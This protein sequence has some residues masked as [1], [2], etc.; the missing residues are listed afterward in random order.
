MHHHRHLRAALD[1]AVRRHLDEVHPR[2]AV[3][4]V[5]AAEE[6]GDA[7]QVILRRHDVP[8]LRPEF[9]EL[10]DDVLELRQLRVAHTVLVLVVLVRAVGTE[11]DLRAP[12][13]GLLRQRDDMVDVLVHDDGVEADVVE[14][15][16]RELG[17]EGFEMLRE[18]GQLALLVVLFIDVIPRNR[19]LVHAVVADFLELLLREEL[20]VRDHRQI[21][22]MRAHLVDDLDEILP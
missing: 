16:G 21:G 5:A 9:E 22:A 6:L 13:I 19:H 17:D 15:L 7:L 2:A 20:A 14:A 12:L 1:V 18:P 8:L 10:A 4:D 3:L 11:R